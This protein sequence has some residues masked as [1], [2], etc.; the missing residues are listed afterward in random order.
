MD[1]Y[2]QQSKSIPQKNII[3]AAELF[4]LY[5][6]F[7][8]L[9]QCGGVV[10]LDKIGIE[11]IPGNLYSRIILFIFSVVVFLRITFT[12]FY[13]LKRKI[14]WEESLS[15]SIAFALYYIG[16]ALLG[17]QRTSSLDWLDVLAI[18]IFVTGSFLNTFSE[19]Q[20]H[21]WKLRPENK[22]RL[23]TKGLFGYAMHINFFGDLLWVVAFALTTRNPWS[24]VIPL[25]LFC[26]FAFYNI[27]KLDAH[28]KQKYSKQFPDYQK[29]TK[30]LVPFIY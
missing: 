20:R 16:F 25:F 14:P 23:Y 11:A 8:I 24:V 6:S 27:P 13:L 3:V 21:F 1:L 2:S 22:G 26:F 18:L 17:Y 7:W 29:C 4:L 19:I 9:F 15:I 28:L 12:L 5:F 10:V 30:R